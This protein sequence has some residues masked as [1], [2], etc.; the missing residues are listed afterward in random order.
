MV[1]SAWSV[2]FQP[3]YLV[4]PAQVDRRQLLHPIHQIGL[5][6]ELLQVDESGPLVPLLRQ[7]IE[8]IQ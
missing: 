1:S 7:Q 8:L 5:G 2:L 3:G 6:I 4:A